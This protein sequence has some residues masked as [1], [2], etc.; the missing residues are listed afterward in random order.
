M[1]RK[2]E[3]AIKL[4]RREEGNQSPEVRLL[5]SPQNRWSLFQAAE[6]LNH[7][8]LEKFLLLLEPQAFIPL[9]ILRIRV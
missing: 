2:K 5:M 9:Q 1:E 7:M 6:H 3:W 8:P 4:K